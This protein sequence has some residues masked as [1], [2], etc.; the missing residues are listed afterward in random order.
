MVSILVKKQIDAHDGSVKILVCCIFY[1]DHKWMCWLLFFLP[2]YLPQPYMSSASLV[3]TCNFKACSRYFLGNQL[4]MF[5]LFLQ[6]PDQTKFCFDVTIFLQTTQILQSAIQ[7]QLKKMRDKH[8]FLLY[9]SSSLL[10]KRLTHVYGLTLMSFF[11]KIMTE[12]YEACPIITPNSFFFK[13][14]IMGHHF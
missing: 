11:I 5:V 2:G 9:V 4:E 7:Y 12:N 1:V 14:V 3:L 6:L 10:K 13:R 8:V